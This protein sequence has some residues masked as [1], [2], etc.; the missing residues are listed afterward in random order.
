M[1]SRKIKNKYIGLLWIGFMILS[2]LSTVQTVAAQTYTEGY[3]E[4]E[5]KEEAIIITCYF[6]TETEITLP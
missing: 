6:G 4:Y 5:V 1:K 3:Y 2:L